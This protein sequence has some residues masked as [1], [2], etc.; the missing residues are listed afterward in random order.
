METDSKLTAATAP[1]DA[2]PRVASDDSRGFMALFSRLWRDSVRDRGFWPTIARATSALAETVLGS[3]PSRRRLRFDDLDYDF[4]HNVN[5]TRSN[6]GFATRFLT[7][8]VESPY[9]ASEPWLFEQIMQALPIA[10]GDFTFIDLGSGKG[11]TLLMAAQHG[12]GKAIGVEL[13]PELHLAAE[14]NISKF[15]AD[16]SPG[17]AMQCLCMN[18]RDFQ[19]PAGPLVIY[20]FNPFPQPV[21]AAVL[22]NLH[23]SWQTDPRPVFVTYR[24]V[25]LENLLAASGWLEKIAG[26]EQWA[27]YKNRMIG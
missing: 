12:F 16:R 20:L 2:E 1:D 9:F 5:T 13:I 4:D 23:T 15:S 10:F 3:L 26:T 24:Y 6:V 11:R 27:I 8:F 14:Q 17:T 19:F 7:T 21:F 25:E 18:A 22:T